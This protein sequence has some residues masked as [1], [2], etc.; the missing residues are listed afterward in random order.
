MNKR[1]PIE[2]AIQTQNLSK[3]H[4]KKLK[5]AESARQFAETT[6]GLEKSNNYTSFVKLNGPYVTHL[7]TVAP[8]FELKSHKWWF[9]IVGQLPYKGFTTK[10]E[11]IEESRSFSEELYDTYIRGVSAY[12][13][14]GWFDDPLFSS[15]LNYSDHRLVNLIIHET[16]H[17]TLY[18]KSNANFNERL[19]TFFANK[20]TE[21]FYKQLEGEASSTLIKIKKESKDKNIFSKFISHEIKSLGSWYKKNSINMTHEIK[22]ERLLEIQ[23]NFISN[24][25]PKLNIYSYH[26][27][28]SKPLNN[29]QILAYKTYVYD[30][31]DFETAFM[32]FNGNFKEFMSFCKRLAKDD[33]PEKSLRDF[34]KPK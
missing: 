9:P 10:D 34:I 27:F 16:V 23:N 4:I 18:I 15:H 31:S 2:E 28:T 21:A 30:Q 17:V 14:L 7:L 20:G 22:S 25:K 1:V 12:S 29:A 13:T 3:R 8:A 33:D 19:A 6:L 32:K 11:A 26:S 5:L 24:V